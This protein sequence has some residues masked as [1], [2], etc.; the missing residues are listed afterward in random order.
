MR[1]ND[2]D[3]LLNFEIRPTDIFLMT[4]PKS[5]KWFA[6]LQPFPF[7][8]AYLG[9]NFFILFIFVW[10]DSAL[11][12]HSKKIVVLIPTRELSV[13][14]LHVLRLC[15]SS[16]SLVFT[17][18]VWTQQILIQI[19]SASHPGWVEDVTNRMQA[20]FLEGKMV[21]DPYRQRNDPRIFNTHLPP[22]MIPRGVKEKQIKVVPIKK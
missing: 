7:S 19:I 3:E 15:D 9:I 8:F 4:Y 22:Y 12:H 1:P 6:K 17:G 13:L 20:P 18:T 14:S 16:S 10:H 5:G 11:S 21:D 2:F